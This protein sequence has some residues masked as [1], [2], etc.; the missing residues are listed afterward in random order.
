VL[1]EE[2]P[3]MSFEKLSERTVTAPADAAAP[4]LTQRARQTRRVRISETV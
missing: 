1:A 4:A 2:P 3:P